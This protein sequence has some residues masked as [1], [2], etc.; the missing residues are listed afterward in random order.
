MARGKADLVR[1]SIGACTGKGQ[2]PR[3][4]ISPL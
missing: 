3:P 4:G 2:R 1:C